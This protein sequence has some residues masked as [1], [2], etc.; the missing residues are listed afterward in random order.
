MWGSADRLRHRLVVSSVV[1]V[2]VFQMACF[3]NASTPF[4]P[5]SVQNTPARGN[6]QNNR[7]PDSSVLG[8]NNIDKTIWTGTIGEYDLSWTT[9]DLLLKKGSFEESIFLSYAKR[10][11]DKLIST[12]G[13]SP[14]CNMAFSFEILSIV[15]HLISAE[16][17]SYADCVGAGAQGL[18]TRLVTFR[19]GSMGALSDP[20]ANPI[21][22]TDLFPEDE[23][24]QGLLRLPEIQR[25]LET[26]GKNPRPTTLRGLMAM[27]RLSGADGVD[28]SG[29]TL[30]SASLSRFYFGDVKESNRIL[31][32]VELTTNGAAASHPRLMLDL[33]TPDSLK[34]PVRLAC[35]RQEGFL[36]KDAGAV[37]SG[38]MTT[39]ILP[40]Q[41][42]AR[43]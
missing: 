41:G 24:L 2:V 8:E 3:E 22:L 13:K 38:L 23:I 18:E 39:I 26:V 5:A 43:D 7:G 37:S 12:V 35:L 25:T 20:I 27:L 11:V 10:A 31:V 36:A 21:K 15:N 28:N 33:P 42:K 19:I 16:Q 17:T 4:R 30:S 1:T 14:D 32:S 29:H 40:L 34:E 9:T 6:V